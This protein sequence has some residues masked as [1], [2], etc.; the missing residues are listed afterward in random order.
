MA[1]DY[2]RGADYILYLNTGSWASP[3]YVRIKAVDGLGCSANPEDVEVPESGSDTG[4]LHGEKDPEITGRLLDDAGDANVET[5][6]AA[7]YSGAQVSLALSRG[8]IATTGN[9]FVRME[10]VL[11]APLDADRGA[12]G[13][14]QFTA[15]RHANSDNVFTR[16]TA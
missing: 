16:G 8:A 10:C 13:S 2:K 15:K 5:L 7:I 4:H 11:F 3:T 12:T 14:H 9:K 1:K 6:I